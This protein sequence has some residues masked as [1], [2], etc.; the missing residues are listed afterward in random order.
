[1]PSRNGLQL[2]VTYRQSSVKREELLAFGHITNDI[3]GNNGLLPGDYRVVH[4]AMKFVF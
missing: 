3:S 2:D 1:V 4:L